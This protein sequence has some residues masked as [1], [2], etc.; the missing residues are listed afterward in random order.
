MIRFFL[1]FALL[2]TAS[3]SAQVPCIPAPESWKTDGAG[4]AAV[5]YKPDTV[6]IH[7]GNSSSCV[8]CATAMALELMRGTPHSPEWLYGISRKGRIVLG[9]GSLCGWA[10]V[11]ARDYGTLP[12][13]GYAALGHDL[14]FYDPDLSEDWARGPP[15]E[16]FQIAALYKTS[17][18]YHIHDWEELRGALK[19]GYPVI[20][21][22]NV[23]FGS[24]TG[25]IRNKRGELKARWWSRW[26]H[27]MVFVGYD[28]VGEHKAALLLNSWGPNWV[29]GPQRVGD[30]PEGSF[31]AEKKTV[32]RML[33]YGDAYALVP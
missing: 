27:A 8:G 13:T 9:P 12:A 20:V 1:I 15:E 28:D 3:A 10:V 29:S 31:W 22:S 19:N 14:T 23:G 4:T 21:G 30:E 25:Q 32:E 6:A 2:F 18:Y 5:L 11:A 24:Q 17:G 26:A 33:N 16:L 7:Q